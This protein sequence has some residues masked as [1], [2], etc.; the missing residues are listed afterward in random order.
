MRAIEPAFLMSLQWYSCGAYNTLSALSRPDLQTLADRIV[1]FTC[2]TPIARDS[3]GKFPSRDIPWFGEI[4]IVHA[5]AVGGSILV[6]QQLANKV[7]TREELA[8][9]SEILAACVEGYSMWELF[10]MG[11]GV[12]CSSDPISVLDPGSLQFRFSG[13]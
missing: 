6:W 12:D 3:K 10:E 11:I 13:L 2:E 1:D 4:S 9:K 7:E 8:D 5:V